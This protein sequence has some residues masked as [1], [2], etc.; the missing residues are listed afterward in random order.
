MNSLLNI[1]NKNIII[2]DDLLTTGA[3]ASEMAL[4]LKK[5]GAAT[6]GVFTLAVTL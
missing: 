2:I 5:N 4:T 1:K 3:T 6:V